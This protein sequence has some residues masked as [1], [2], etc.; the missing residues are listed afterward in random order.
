MNTGR[1]RLL[2]Q[3]GAAVLQD[4]NQAYGNPE[5]NFKNIAEVWNWYLKGKP[6]HATSAEEPVNITL[7]G[8]DIAHMMTLLKMARLKTNRTHE[9]SM[10]DAAGYQ[11]CAADFVK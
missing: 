9:D 5:D 6:T 1:E 7:D 4:R 3:V 2:E 10:V 11:A 8:L